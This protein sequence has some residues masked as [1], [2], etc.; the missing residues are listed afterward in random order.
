MDKT[1]IKDT[2]KAH[3]Y[4]LNEISFMTSP[5]ELKELIETNIEKLNIIDVRKYEDYMN[6]HIPFAIH[7]PFDD[8]EEHLKMLNKDKINIVYGYSLYC[9]R[10]AKAGAMIARENYPVMELKG[11]FKIWDKL[12]F[13]IVSN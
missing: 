1:Y 5:F 3:E 9:K 12:G 11:G 8:L 13:D 2:K 7:I 6:G 4:F 10:G